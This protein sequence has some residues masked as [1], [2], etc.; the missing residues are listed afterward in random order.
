MRYGLILLLSIAACGERIATKER[1]PRMSKDRELGIA[2]D[3]APR[4]SKDLASRISAAEFPAMAARIDLFEERINAKNPAVR[5]RALGEVTRYNVLRSREMIRFLYAMMNDPD[6]PVSLYATNALHG[7]WVHIAPRDLPDTLHGYS[8]RKLVAGDVKERRRLL[9]HLGF[10]VGAAAI[11]AGLCQVK[12]AIPLLV[13][14]AK[15]QRP[16]NW[17]Q[18]ARALSD[19]GSRKEATAAFAALSKDQLARFHK[20]ND[21]WDPRNQN[22]GAGFSGMG[23][24]QLD[25][26]RVMLPGHTYM[27][28]RHD[29]THPYYAILAC[30][31]LAEMGA[32]WRTI[33]LNRMVEVYTLLEATSYR[34]EQTIRN[35]ARLHLYAL[36]GEFFETA[37]DAGA[38]LDA[39]R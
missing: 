6:A 28:A 18:T 17:I 3:L 15:K 25:A 23:H 30:R 14:N 13:R 5:R 35:E 34:N 20:R 36:T 38:W 26:P 39:Q 8:T 12:E 22:I 9:E 11:V 32:V 10:G 16:R 24:P 27:G 33:G 37:A 2:K 19:L 31:G 1:E 29:G 4:V 7:L 21:Q